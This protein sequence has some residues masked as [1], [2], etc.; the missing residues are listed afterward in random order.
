MSEITIYGSPMSEIT[1]YGSP[2]SESEKGMEIRNWKV[3]ES[4]RK[5]SKVLERVT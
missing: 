5:D 4:L 3:L 2:M 1:I